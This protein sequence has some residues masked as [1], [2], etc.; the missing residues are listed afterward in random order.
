MFYAPVP[1]L[2]VDPLVLTSAEQV[3]W[4]TKNGVPFVAQ[5]G[6]HAW[7]SWF[8]IDDGGLVINLRKL[9]T[10]DIDMEKGEA[11]LGGG[12]T[13]VD[14]LRA[15]KE[16]KAHIGEFLKRQPGGAFRG[17]LTWEVLGVCNS[18]GSV[19]SMIGG[20]TGF[21]MVGIFSF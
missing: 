3:Q 4:A 21:L 20:G 2:L 18:V 14:V 10:V 16:K 6:G 13:M 17:P 19:S 5:S 12:V 9:S 8:R 7:S 1:Y 11:V 15:A